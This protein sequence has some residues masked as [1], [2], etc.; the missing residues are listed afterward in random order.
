MAL[1]Q[2]RDGGKVDV[3]VVPVEPIPVEPEAAPVPTVTETVHPGYSSIY[4]LLTSKIQSPLLQSHLA[5]SYDAAEH[6][7]SLRGDDSQAG[8]TKTKPFR[9]VAL[10][11]CLGSLI[12]L[13]GES[14]HSNKK[15]IG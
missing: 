15:L 4:H 8:T 3:E 12:F 11:I 10:C 13:Q 1:G 5:S 7:T 6:D 14:Y 9:N 2:E